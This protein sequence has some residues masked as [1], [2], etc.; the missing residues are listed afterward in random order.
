MYECSI[1]PRPGPHLLEPSH[2]P[3]NHPR[4]GVDDRQLKGSAVREA[5]G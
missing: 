4:L 1:S 3:I 2:L 5:K